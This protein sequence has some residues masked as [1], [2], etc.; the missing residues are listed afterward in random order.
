MYK[1]KIDHDGPYVAVK[2]LR[3]DLQVDV[4]DLLGKLLQNELNVAQSHPFVVQLLG[5][6]SKDP[7]AL[8]YKYM[9]GGD[10]RQVVQSEET[11]ARLNLR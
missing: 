3:A 6:C 1:A 10:F 9:G 7:A 8:V 5:Y 4:G 11:R 2:V